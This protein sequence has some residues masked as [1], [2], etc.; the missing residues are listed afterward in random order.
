[1][2]LEKN[3]NGMKIFSW[4]IQHG[5][6]SR[7]NV[8]L[9]ELK[10]NGD[11][12][13][14]ILTE[15]RLNN[16]GVKIKDFLSELGFQHQFTPTDNIKINTVLVASKIEVEFSIGIGLGI[17][18]HR[19]V[20]VKWGYFHLIAAYFPQRKEK[21]AVFN[22]LSTQLES[23]PLDTVLIV[24][25]DMNTGIHYLDETANSFFCS[26]DFQAIQAKGLLD[27]WRLLNGELRE[28]SWYF[29]NGNG[30][31]IDHFLINSEYRHLVKDCYYHHKARE[32]KVSDHSQMVLVLK[33]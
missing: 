8:I 10:K 6:G 22:F 18:T 31:R 4:N 1:M 15:F 12:S 14:I 26:N 24:A 23:K 33:Q 25:G 19:V 20:S 17:H 3:N 11:S 5:G 27:A 30:F 2:L 9:S 28:Y 13:V 7:L 29:R 21:R 16:N 32:E